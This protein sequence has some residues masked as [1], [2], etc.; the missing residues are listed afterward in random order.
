MPNLS[1][2]SALS[3][4]TIS[5]VV[6]RPHIEI[7]AQ[8]KSLG[9]NGPRLHADTVKLGAAKQRAN[10]YRADSNSRLHQPQP[11]KRTGKQRDS[12]PQK[13]DAEPT[14]QGSK[15]Q[16]ATARRAIVNL[17]QSKAV[18]MQLRQRAR[19]EKSRVMTNTDPELRFSRSVKAS[20]KRE[21]ASQR[22]ATSPVPSHANSYVSLVKSL[23]AS[24]TA[25]PTTSRTATLAE[26]TRSAHSSRSASPTPSG[27]FGRANPSVPKS[28]SANSIRSENSDGYQMV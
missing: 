2:S 16:S 17:G 4:A 27:L 28:I 19:D 7:H 5:M 12:L 1:Q 10:T 18:R 8:P 26:S 15:L 13:V 24:M 6:P 14:A 11:A 20:L 9:T 21:A 23:M 3:L 25:S 22:M